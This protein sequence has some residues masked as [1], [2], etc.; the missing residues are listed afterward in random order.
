MTAQDFDKL[1]EQQ[2]DSIRK[3]LLSKANEYA[4]A[5]DRLHN[6]K[7]ASIDFGDKPAEA[8]WGYMLKHLMSVRD[9]A[10]GIRKGTVEM[11]DEKIG[12]SINYLILMKAILLEEMR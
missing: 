5:S 9:L 6:F 1:V 11:I 4:V 3:V 10:K 8:C 12:D 7:S 2:I